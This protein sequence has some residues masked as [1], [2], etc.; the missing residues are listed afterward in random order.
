MIRRK[1]VEQKSTRNHPWFKKIIVPMSL[2]EMNS[3]KDFYAILI[4]IGKATGAT[5]YNDRLTERD[6]EI[7]KP[8]VCCNKPMT[9]K[10]TA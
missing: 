8:S 5:M 2:M 9:S 4:E 7:T 6:N 10:A 1:I 3:N